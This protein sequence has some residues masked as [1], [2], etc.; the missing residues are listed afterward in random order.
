MKTQSRYS[1]KFRWL[2]CKMAERNWS[3]KDGKDLYE[4][5]YWLLQKVYSETDLVKYNGRYT[6][7]KIVYMYIPG[8]YTID[9]IPIIVDVHIE[10]GYPPEGVI[11]MSFHQLKQTFSNNKYED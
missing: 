4:F 6:R 7:G 8:D 1:K 9:R 3:I 5:P 10:L 11:C 2:D